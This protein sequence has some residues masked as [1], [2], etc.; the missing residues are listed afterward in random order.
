M[1]RKR[2]IGADRL[3][4][5]PAV[6][7]LEVGDTTPPL[8]VM[9]ERRD[10]VAAYQVPATLES[11]DANVLAPDARF[12][13]RFVAK[14]FGGTQIRAVYRGREVLADVTVTGRRFAEVKTTLNAGA[15]DFDVLIEVLAAEAEGPLEY[16]VYRAGQTAAETW[17]AAQ[18]APFGQGRQ[19]TLRS[20]R[21]RQGPSSTVYHLMVEA[22]DPSGGSVQQ[23]P[24][25]F[26]LRPQLET[27]D[28]R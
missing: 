11:M 3:R 21:M 25:T 27:V 16:R 2:P 8:A 26:R 4:I 6:I 1:S 14:A 12:P 17:V 20:P 15:D 28:P 23:Y 10:G 9:A 19:V 7:G 5:E 24:L 22:R 18:E 13:G